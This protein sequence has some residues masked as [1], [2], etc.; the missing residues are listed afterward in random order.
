MKEG[1]P[2]CL[3]TTRKVSFK[4]EK[5]KMVVSSVCLST[6]AGHGLDKGSE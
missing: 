4:K 2:D 5:K 3:K 6:F 1:E